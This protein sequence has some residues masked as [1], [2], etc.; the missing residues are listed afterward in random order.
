MKEFTVTENEAGQRFDKLLSKYL[1][2]A[3]AGFLYKMLRKKNITLNGKKASGSEHTKTGDQVRLFLS[4][5]TYRKFSKSQSLDFGKPLS[6]QSVVYE[7]DDIC[8]I[9]KPAGVL[10]Q[11]SSPSDHSVSEQFLSYLLQ[12]GDIT[13][14]SL[15]TF[16]PS[17]CNRLDRNTSGLTLAGKTLAG[18]QGLSAVLKDRSLHKYYLC[19]V[20]GKITKSGHLSGSLVKD[21]AHN[22]VSVS[23]SADGEGKRI[24]T[25]YEPLWT[26]GEI[27]LLQ[28]L[29]IT[30]RTH[31]IRAHLSFAHHPI[32]GDPKY[33]LDPACLKLTKQ[34]G[35]RG[36]L[37]HAYRMEFPQMD[38]EL[39]DLSGRV[40]TAPLPHAF[41]ALL[42]ERGCCTKSLG[43]KA[44]KGV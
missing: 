29:L 10:A 1:S 38:G 16:R 40:F 4:E 15:Q 7:D 14:E 18:L 25:S 31:Q 41:A 26:D 5:E 43:R 44:S 23:G 8:I 17:V 34:Y 20:L 9:N 33:G 24:E 6:S 28:V 13:R 2:S 19:P 36:Q 30:G 35:L 22:R 39:K 27:T 37:L 21:G 32:L 3:P 11:K 12:K 42:E